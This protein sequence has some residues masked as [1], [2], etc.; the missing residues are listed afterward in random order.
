M[1]SRKLSVTIAVVALSC[2]LLRADFLTIYGS[3]LYDS[4]TNTGYQDSGGPAFYFNGG[5]LETLGKYGPGGGE[6]RAVRWEKSGAFV[7]LA[8]LGTSSTGAGGSAVNDVNG[9]GIAVGG[10]LKYV[11][12]VEKGS[13]AVR[14]D[15]SGAVSELGNLGTTADGKTSARAE[16]VNA[17]GIMAGTANKYVSGVSKGE[18]AVRWN[19]SGTPTELGGLGEDINGVATNVAL[20]INDGGT[21][22]G[23]SYKFIN[24]VDK[25]WRAVRW[26]GS[27]TVATELATLGTDS[28]GI[29][30]QSNLARKINNA[31]IAIGESDKFQGGSFVGVR[32][33]RW[34]PGGAAVTELGNLGIAADGTTYGNTS[35]IN[36]A[37]TIV[38][39]MTKYF[40]GANLGNRA[41][42]WNAGSTAAIELGNLGTAG[43]FTDTGAWAIN[44]SG[45]IAGYAEKFLADPKSHA[46]IW[47][48]DGIA[49]DLNNFVDP[50]S[51]WVVLVDAREIDDNNWV[52]GMGIFDPDGAGPKEG[53]PRTFL[54]QIPEPGSLWLVLFTLGV[55]LHRRGW[56]MR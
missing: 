52:S 29:S 24:G 21:V 19:A 50:A 56:K 39:R 12:N 8:R 17:F 47:G 3:P 35:D 34:A 42:R 23:A 4:T 18:Y 41:V 37:G 22:V 7:E 30:G 48:V 1:N 40:N 6:S 32:P 55:G 13:R 53:F 11:S 14:W 28:S 33:V 43:G 20:D 46:V 15:A 51:G 9:A 54:M 49:I 26:D 38:G 45:L 16:A 2:G 44:G 27:S 31:G 25:G 10:S 36:E 5:V